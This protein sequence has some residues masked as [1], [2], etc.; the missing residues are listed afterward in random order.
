MQPGTDCVEKEVSIILVDHPDQFDID[1][2][3]DDEDL[4]QRLQITLRSADMDRCKRQHTTKC[5]GF[6]LSSC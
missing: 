1:I 2:P 5:L 6:S 4:V 3:H